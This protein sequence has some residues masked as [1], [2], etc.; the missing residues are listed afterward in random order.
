[1]SLNYVYLLI[2]D[3]QITAVPFHFVYTSWNMID[4]IAKKTY[5]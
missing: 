1:M 5:R 2:Y 3:V 4:K